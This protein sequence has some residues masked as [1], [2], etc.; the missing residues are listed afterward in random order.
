MHVDRRRRDGR[1]HRG[2]VRDARPHR[3]AAGPGAPSASRPR[4]SARRE[5]FKRAPARRAPRA[6]RRSIGSMPDVAGEGVAARR[7]RHRGDLREPRGEARA[8]RAARARR[9]SPTRSSP[10]TRPASSS[11]TSPPR[12]SDPARLVGI[13]FFN[14]VPQMQLVEVVVGREHRRRSSRSK[15]AAFVRQIDKLPLP[16]KDSPGFL[17]NRVLGPY[18]HKALRLRRRRHVAGDARRGHGAV[19]HADGPDRARRHRRAGHLPRRGQGARQDDRGAQGLANKVALGHLG[20][21]TGQG[22]YRWENGKAVKGQPDAVRRR[23]G[24]DA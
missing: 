9:R 10:P 6:R 23:A 12:C 3:H 13:H 2:V 20:K 1:R 17:V 18:L 8:V 19:R 7:R 11:P 22:I 16:V 14:P 24:A 5:L 15:A 4:S 21:K